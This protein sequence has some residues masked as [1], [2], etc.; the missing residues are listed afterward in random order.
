MIVAL[1]DSGLGMLPTAARLRQARPELD[2][3]LM[4]DPDN[5]PWGPKPDGWVVD[6]VVGTAQHAVELGAEVVVLPCNTASVTALSHV[7][8]ALG[9]TIP[10]VGTVPAIKPAAAVSDR[11]AIWATAATTAS[12]Y[13]GR[14]IEQ[15]AS[16]RTV[17]SVACHGLADSID[18]GD[19]RG[20]G[21]A[22]TAAVAATPADV[23]SIVLGCTHY[24]LVLDRIVSQLPGD[25][26]MFDSAEAVA[27]QTVRRVDEVGSSGSG[28]GRV[29]VW[30]SGI[31]GDLPA[32]AQRYREGKLLR[33]DARAEQH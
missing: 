15:F 22:I 12:A 27:N 33:G 6:R 5:A 21:A 26:T 11:I 13:Q 3:V 8:A 24:P 17:T 2:L 23:E 20:I 25:V 31:E 7:R 29:S 32:S 16:H 4:M 18:R 1:I 10:V 28:T 14:L 30:L 9:D 19:E